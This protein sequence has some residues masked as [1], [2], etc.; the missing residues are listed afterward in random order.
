MTFRAPMYKGIQ[1]SVRRTAFLLVALLILSGCTQ[2][3]RLVI[4]KA[5]SAG[6][7][8]LDPFFDEKSGLGVDA[9]V[10]GER[11][12]GGLQQGNTPGLYG[13]SRKQGA[14][15]VDRLKEFLIDP[16]N[17]RKAKEWARVAGISPDAI[18]EYVDQ[19]TPVLLRHDTLVRNHDY[20]KG[21]A[22]AYDALLEAGIAV[23]VNDQGLPVVK[24]SCG[25]PLRTFEGDREDISVRFE[26]GNEKWPSFRDDSVVSVEPSPTKLDRIALVDVTDPDKGIE[27]PVGTDGSEDR[28]F[29]ARRDGEATGEPG[30]PGEPGSAS[31]TETSTDTPT[32]ADPTEPDPTDPSDPTE[33]D[34]TEPDPTTPDP[35][36]TSTP[37]TDTPPTPTPTDTEPVGASPPPSTD[38]ATP[39]SDD[40]PRTSSSPPTSEPVTS[41]PATS[42]PVTSDPATDAPVSGEP[43]ASAV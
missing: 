1:S 35:T 39:P 33:P 40:P 12:R 3:D 24:C 26:G 11:P 43:A 22:V 15:D 42:A 19:L 20:K 7:P 34:P 8:A 14:C 21:R 32:P 5:V 4:V 27:R 9:E 31:P 2:A 36:Q 30:T 25:N 10:R 23:L 16:E 37:P 41:E 28:T 38:S 29:D 18:E 17:R 13:G 6:V